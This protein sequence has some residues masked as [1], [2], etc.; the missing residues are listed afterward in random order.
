MFL[1]RS[2]TDPKTGEGLARKR[3][4]G[5]RMERCVMAAVDWFGLDNWFTQRNKTEVDSDRARDL[6]RGAYKNSGGVTPDLQRVYNSY[7][8]NERKRDDERREG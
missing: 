7:L 8:A 4:A 6:V 5:G 3:W 2:P 1:V